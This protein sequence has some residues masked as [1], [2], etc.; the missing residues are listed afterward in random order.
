MAEEL[1]NGFR[2]IKLEALERFV[3]EAN[4]LVGE[5]SKEAGEHTCELRIYTED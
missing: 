5:D 1:V 3:N 4:Q 2:R